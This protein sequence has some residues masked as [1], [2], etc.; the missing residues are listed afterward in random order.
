MLTKTGLALISTT[1]SVNRDVF[2]KQK[3][4]SSE[5]EKRLIGPPPWRRVAEP[6]VT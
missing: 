4:R 1:N 5:K 3:F 2:N 6:I